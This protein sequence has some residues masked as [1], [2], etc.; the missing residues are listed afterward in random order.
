MVC[1]RHI[2]VYVLVPVYV[3]VVFVFNDFSGEVVVPYVN[4]STSEVVT[5]TKYKKLYL[6]SGIYKQ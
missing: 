3:K 2:F 6:K 4:I 1:P 5:N